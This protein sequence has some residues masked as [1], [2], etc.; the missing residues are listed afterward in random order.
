MVHQGPGHS[1]SE[2][3]CLFKLFFTNAIWDYVCKSYIVRSN[4]LGAATMEIPSMHVLHEY[5]INLGQMHNIR[6]GL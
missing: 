2:K 4:T 6:D 5:W 3:S 1:H